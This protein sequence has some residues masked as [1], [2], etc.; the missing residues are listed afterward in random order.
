MLTPVM[1]TLARNPMVVRNKEFNEYIR[2]N[3]DQKILTVY[4]FTLQ[5]F[6]KQ[7]EKQLIS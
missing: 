5:D 2:A 6:T 7:Q 4:G 1:A 3:Y